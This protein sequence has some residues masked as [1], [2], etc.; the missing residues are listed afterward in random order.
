LGERR[1]QNAERIEPVEEGLVGIAIERIKVG[2][3]AV[4]APVNNFIGIVAA[5]AAIVGMVA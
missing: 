2:L 5:V 4:V 1:H 3:A